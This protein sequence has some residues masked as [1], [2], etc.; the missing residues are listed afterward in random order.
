MVIYLGIFHRALFNKLYKMKHTI[1]YLVLLSFFISCSDESDS[2]DFLFDVQAVSKKE[3]K[4]H[5]LDVETIT[6][7]DV[8][9][10]YSGSLNYDNQE[11]NFVDQRFGWIFVF[12]KDGQLIDKKL[13]QGEGPN[14]LNTAFV[15][16]YLQLKNGKN[17][18]W[19]SSFDIHIHDALMNREK[20]YILGWEGEQSQR[21][22]RENPKP[23]PKEFGLYTLDYQNMILREDANGNVYI[24]IY[25]E[26][27]NFNAYQSKRYYKEGRILAKLN[28]KTQ[29]VEAL[30][31][32][33]SPEYLKYNYVGHHSFFSYDISNK[34]EFYVSHEIDSLIYVYDKNFQNIRTFGNSGRD[35]VTD[36]TEYPV[37]DIKKFQDLY[38]NDRPFKSW[39]GA[40]EY[41]DEFDL[42]FRS[43][44]KGN[45][46][47]QDGLQIYKGDLLIADIDVPKGLEV[48][49]YIA[50]YFY[51]EAILKDEE[52]SISAFRFT[53][54][55]EI[56]K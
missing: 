12:D 55:E 23:D 40:V 2:R 42:L 30:L 16:G 20:Q 52:L 14:E 7:S 43:Y 28:L 21:L 4:V 46:L 38:F 39:Y 6:F 49:G 35:M 45:S 10:S 24:P 19:G 9:S 31:G 37:L 15:D 25:G 50:P 22:V 1:F 56:L 36:Y 41:F 29:K 34:D 26:N 44:N 48:K 27:N 13:G 33:R 47:T 32:A 18:F 5:E 3:I 51:S 54:P 8:E 11:I 17:L 53:L